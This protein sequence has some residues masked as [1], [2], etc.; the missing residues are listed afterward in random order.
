M[1]KILYVDD[2]AVARE[3]VGDTLREAGHDVRSAGSGT[4]AMQL[5]LAEAADILVLDVQ[6]PE[7][8]GDRLAKVIRKSLSP[9]YPKTI[10]FSSLPVPDLRRLGRKLHADGFVQ[11][12]APKSAL[13]ETV[14]AVE[15]R[16]RELAAEEGLITDE[17][18]PRRGVPDPVDV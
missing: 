6:M 2:D 4:E 3:V 13:L 15:K 9:P 5:L 7:F 18:G 16:R 17:T 1:A 14:A 10:L 8:S 12:G 11:K